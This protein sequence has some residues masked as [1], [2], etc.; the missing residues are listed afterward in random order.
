MDGGIG[1]Q[2]QQR[3]D[4]YR[5]NPQAL[6]M[7]YQQNQQLIDLLALQK[8]KS[9]KE[10]A[11][12]DMQMKMQGE[13]GTIAE[14]RE[15]QVQALTQQEVA[16]K[17]M[18]SVPNMEQGIG[19][20]PYPE[21]PPSGI[22]SFQEGGEVEDEDE[23]E[24]EESLAYRYG[25][26]G[27]I[28]E[29]AQEIPGFLKRGLLALENL[30]SPIPDPD[31][32]ERPRTEPPM[33][34]EALPV[35][36][37]PA[38]TPEQFVVEQAPQ[39]AGAPAAIAPDELGEEFLEMARTLMNADPE[40]ARDA[41]RKA[42]QEAYGYT[43]EELAQLREGLDPRSRA[44][45]RFQAFGRGAAGGAS[46]L[47]AL[48]GGSAS[49]QAE[50]QRQREELAKIVSANRAI[51]EKAFG[52]GQSPYEQ[53]MTSVR[54]GL[55]SGQQEIASQRRSMDAQRKVI[56]DQ[57]L[58]NNKQLAD[59]SQYDMERADKAREAAIESLTSQTSPYAPMYRDAISS[60]QT[61]MKRGSEE[62]ARIARAD[63]SRIVDMAVSDILGPPS[64][65]FGQ[66][67]RLSGP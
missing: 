41:E 32:P 59:I 1:N 65:G 24:D 23:V 57:I 13:P 2:V 6:A 55:S 30:I 7:Q 60:L 45:E 26:L 12:R 33:P 38:A 58:A 50:L 44:W 43:P 56:A 47:A 64:S 48:T 8:L 10:A 67:R 46:G 40:A 51:R 14:Q 29:E 11:A 53:T 42:A 18:G 4:A 66:A 61:A 3:V 19:S 37:Q 15:Q 35:S 54:Q 27:P 17:L 25:G 16:Q 5:S 63:I 62:E 36:E 34:D 31:A 49:S 52:A 22:A 39:G 21:A 9:E 28:L 20:L